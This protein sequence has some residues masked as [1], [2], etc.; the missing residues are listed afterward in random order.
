MRLPKRPEDPDKT[1]YL[2]DYYAAQEF[3]LKLAPF[4]NYDKNG[5]LKFYDK[6][7]I[8]ISGKHL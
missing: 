3:K 2:T 8:K 5:F 4:K 1:H 6:K 7:N